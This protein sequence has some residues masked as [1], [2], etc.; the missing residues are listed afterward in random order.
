MCECKFC[1]KPLRPDADFCTYCGATANPPKQ[2]NIC[3]NPSCDLHRDLF[4]F[5]EN[6]THCSKCGSLTTIG[7]KIN[8]LL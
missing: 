5:S 3:T 7:K 1:G 8:D 4:Q 6:E 2:E